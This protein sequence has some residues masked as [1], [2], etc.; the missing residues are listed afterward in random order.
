MNNPE[1]YAL[2]LNAVLGIAKARGLEKPGSDVAY[3]CH[4]LIE[5]AIAQAEVWDIPLDEIGLQG[6]DPNA[7]LH[8]PTP[9]A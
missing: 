6:L 1:R 5:E 9:A 8:D 3:V 7:L 2:I 4:E